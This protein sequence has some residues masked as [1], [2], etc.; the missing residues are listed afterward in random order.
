MRRD[1]LQAE[2]WAS[3]K[4]RLNRDGGWG[5]RPVVFVDESGMLSTR[6]MQELTAAVN[7]AG[8]KLVLC[9]D[10]KQLPAIQ[11]SGMFAREAHGSTELKEVWR[12]PNPEQK[13]AWRKMHEGQFRAMLQLL[14]RNGRPRWSDRNREAE[15]QMATDY[16]E[17]ER[18]NPGKFMYATTN[19]MVDPAEV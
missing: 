1:G 5:D 13:Q 10:D 9:G 3:E 15:H 11:R 2:T 16:L 4:I 8:G 7:V 12:N 17:A 14:D 6:A 18:T 19:A